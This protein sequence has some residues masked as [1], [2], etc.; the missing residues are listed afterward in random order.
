MSL[1]PKVATLPEGIGALYGNR[2]ARGAAFWMADVEGVDLSAVDGPW[3][4]GGEPLAGYL[5]VRSDFGRLA[6]WGSAGAKL[7]TTLPTVNRVEVMAEPGATLPA[8]DALLSM[9][10]YPGWRIAGEPEPLEF[11]SAVHGRLPR[12]ADG[13]A[14]WSLAFEP[15]SYR[16]GLFLTALGVGL[17]VAVWRGMKAVHRNQCRRNQSSGL[18][19]DLNPDS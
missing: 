18:P 4:R 7:T 2:A 12:P 11:L 16:L 9:S 17:W 19:S 5:T 10:A 1:Y 6:A 14:H 8:G 3:W 15:F 13:G